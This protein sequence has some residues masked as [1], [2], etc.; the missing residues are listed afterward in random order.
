MSGHKNLFQHDLERDLDNPEF[1][2]AFVRECVKVATIDRIIITLDD[3]RLAQGLS[4]AELARAIGSKPSS[5][6]PL[7]PAEGN[8]TPATLSDLA[9]VLGMRITL[10]PL[11]T[12]EAKALA[13]AT[14]KH[15]KAPRMPAPAKRRVKIP[16]QLGRRPTAR[17]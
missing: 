5:I 13:D 1:R 11:S 9:A 4:K 12:S 8:P 7:F 10:A 2:A 3:A 17:G 14:V 15:K 6:R 16:A